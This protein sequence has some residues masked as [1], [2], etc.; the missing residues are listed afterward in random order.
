MAWVYLFVAALF[1]VGW[2]VGFKL[3]Q[4]QAWRTGGIALALASMTLSMGFLWLAQRQIPI[5]V[6]Y[7]VWTGLGAAGTFLVGALAF[8]EALSLGRAFGVALILGGVVLLKLSS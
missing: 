7:A 6:A 5:G 8:G 4:Q 3:S 2:P 1:E